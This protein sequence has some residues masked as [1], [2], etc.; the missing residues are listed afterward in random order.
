MAVPYDRSQTYEHSAVA[1]KLIDN[2]FDYDPLLMKLLEKAEKK[3]GRTVRHPVEY[4]K[5]TQRGW[6]SG[7]DTL[8]TGDEETDTMTDLPWKAAEVTVALP[9]IE[10]A[11]NE[12][13]TRIL[14]LKK[15][16]WQKAE[17]NM[18]D[19]LITALYGDGTGNDG[20]EIV[21]LKAAVD[22]LCPLST[23]EFNSLQA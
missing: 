19:Q 13:E 2:I 17:R 6:Y 11:K 18:K 3:S 7:L 12:G 8:H 10:I 15:Q 22:K 9:N 16:A 20:K 14:D 23:F 21:G 1:K 5:S 4:A